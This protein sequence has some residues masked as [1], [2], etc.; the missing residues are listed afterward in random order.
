MIIRLAERSDLEAIVA[1]EEG[2]FSAAEAA[3]EAQLRERITTVQ[4]TFLV[5]ELDNHVVGFIA[6]QVV[7]DTDWDDEVFITA[8]PNPKTGGY[9][10]LTGLA[11]DAVFQGQGIGMAL[12]ATMKDLAVM[13]HR[14]GILLTCHEPLIGYYEWNGFVDQGLSTSTLG[15]HQWYQMQWIIPNG[16][17]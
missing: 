17:L 12:L 11:V 1:I 2:A 9:I 16:E 13:Q 5:A 14:Q 6:G 8:R 3:T 10:A 4:E 7:A 15:N